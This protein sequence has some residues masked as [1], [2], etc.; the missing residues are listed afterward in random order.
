[1]PQAKND[2]FDEDLQELAQLYK[3]LAHPAR[4]QILKFLASRDACF[5]G[6]ITEVVPLGRTTVNQHLTELKKAGLIQGTTRGAKTN[7]CLNQQGVDKLNTHGL[8]FC[9]SLQSK[10]CESSNC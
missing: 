8:S 6:D 5:C 2:L 9:N 10:S 7:Y 1:M 4:L 3:A